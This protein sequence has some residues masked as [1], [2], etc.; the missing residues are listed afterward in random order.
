MDNN[1]LCKSCGSIHPRKFGLY[2]G[3]Q[4]YFCNDC[5]SKFK[6][7]DMMFH[8][9]TPTNQVSFKRCKV[10]VF[11]LRSGFSHLLT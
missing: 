10:R 5:G 2:K 7:D 8:M 11:T 4:R 6:A 9:K 1:I 3:V